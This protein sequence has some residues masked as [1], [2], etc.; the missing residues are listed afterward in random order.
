M[1]VISMFVGDYENQWLNQVEEEFGS[2]L[3]NHDE[4]NFNNSG[5]TIELNKDAKASLAKEMKGKD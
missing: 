2:D 1:T 3:S 5:T 4:D